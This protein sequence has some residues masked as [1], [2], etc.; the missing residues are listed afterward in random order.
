MQ[1]QT[2]RPILSRGLAAPWWHRSALAAVL[3]VAATL[4]FG[5]ITD[6]GIRFDDES[7]YAS[8]ARLWHRCARVLTDA[9]ALQAI[10]HLDKQT[11]QGRMDHIGVDF[12]QR[13]NK[14][15]QGY[16]FLA[17]LMMFVVGDS[18]TAL[19][20]TNA[21]CGTLAV[22]V[23]YA[24]GVLLF[25][26]SVGLCGAFLLAVSPYHLLYSRSAL[27]EASAGLFILLAALFW[28]LGRTGRWPWRK[29]FVWSGVALGFAI[30][31]HYRSAYVP[32]VLVV[33]DLFLGQRA[34]T[35]EA[36]E[37]PWPGG[38][39]RVL[40]LC[41]GV[42]IP[43]L[44]LEAVFRAARLGA[45]VTDSFL[46]VT[47]YLEACWNYWLLLQND[48]GGGDGAAWNPQ[49]L[50]AYAGYFVHWHGFAAGALTL[51]GLVVV[52]RVRGA[53]RW[54]AIFVLA[55]VGILL[56]Q[57]HTVARALSTAVPFATLCLAAG[58]QAIVMRCKPSARAV[59]PLMLLVTVIVAEP[60]LVN[61][62]DLYK[63]RSSI[64]DA[65]AFLAE[66]SADSVAVPMDPQKYALYLKDHDIEV[67]RARPKHW[68]NAVEPVLANLRR[69]GVRWLI[70]DPQHWHCRSLNKPWD[71]MFQ[72][73]QAMEE[74]LENNA[75]LVAEF[76]H[77]IDYRWEFM[78]E[79][80]AFGQ[81]SEMK[82]LG[83][84][85]LRIYDIQTSVLAKSQ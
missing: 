71:T 16:T 80:S 22:A 9:E 63:K 65:C 76:P 8:D 31:C 38:M 68:S 14:P 52:I 26:R 13:Y 84:G 50:L 15:C 81:L 29:G 48:L 59:A 23:V 78:S 43:L 2:H 20:V 85:P 67:V 60:G 42:A 39:R 35:V 25:G 11:L 4:R 51:I 33:A 34:K 18:P 40:W 5:G 55:T 75:V 53:A 45:S 72:W 62:L 44:A 49:V 6:V 79:G 54:P 57:R 3:L 7:W 27:A 36:S 1:N 82:A 32:V 24:L 12:R 21:L 41:V 37:T 64:E 56:C 17:S 61:S 83:G 70:T 69:A 58:V 73:W 10:W 77:L 74:H 30:T 46:P 19:L 66:R 28:T 47:T